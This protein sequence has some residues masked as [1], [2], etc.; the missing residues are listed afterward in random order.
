MLQP[1]N[2]LPLV[3]LI[4]GLGA[5][6]LLIKKGCLRPDA[7]DAGPSR[8]VGLVP[9]DLLVA[10]GLMILGPAL[11]VYL[12]PGV[13]G[14]T[15]PEA[16]SD[17]NTLT[18]ARRA[19]LAQA[20]GQLIP[21]L[22][23]LWRASFKPRGPWLIGMIPVKPWRDLRWG[24]LGFLAAVPMI[25]AAIQATVFVGNLF[26]QEA[27]VLAHD[28]LKMLVDSDSQTGTALIIVSAVLVAPIL[29][30]SIFRGIV[31]SVM[32]ETLGESRRWSV[33]IVASIVFMFM[34][35]DL[36]NWENWQALPGLLV[37]GVV[38]GWLY[39]R[40]GSLWPCI[41]LHTLFN[42]LN[43]VMALAVVVSEKQG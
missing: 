41:V 5:L 37:L 20:T 6:G 16:V 15:E 27:P 34:H 21:V 23:L 25:M 29:E 31:Q 14:Q 24:V 26:G 32:V 42:T 2:I 38:L 11:A 8:A 3:I 13:M 1:S 4:L 30:E 12:M 9:A 33:V 19:L 28:M 36:V 35:A 39:E 17:I 18:Y 10:L 22:Y 43:I 7:L 40:T